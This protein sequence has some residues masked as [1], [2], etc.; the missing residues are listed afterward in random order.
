MCALFIIAATP[1]SVQARIPLDLLDMESVTKV[2]FIIMRL[3]SLG[4]IIAFLWTAMHVVVDHGASGEGHVVFFPHAC[5]PHLHDDEGERASEPHAGHHHA[6]THSH[7]T[8]STSSDAPD[9][10]RP[11]S[12]IHDVSIGLAAH[13][14]ASPSL[15]RVYA[16]PPPLLLHVCLP[17]WYRVLLI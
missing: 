4:L 17:L 15:L 7:F 6:D 2:G 8:W 11:M 3:M 1:V 10:R 13:P 14:V 16:F 9:V 12:L 5:P